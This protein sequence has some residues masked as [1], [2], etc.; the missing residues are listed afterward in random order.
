MYTSTSISRKSRK[1]CSGKGGQVQG[2]GEGGLEGSSGWGSEAQRAPG[3]GQG[4]G[5]PKGA[6]PYV[7]QALNAHGVH[8]G[9]G[10]QVQDETV[11][12][13][14]GQAQALQCAPVWGLGTFL[15]AGCWLC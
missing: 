5:P 13:G 10:A 7:L 3:A 11:E 12:G 8:E 15:P 9:E 6:G 14:R 4:S 2:G 1:I